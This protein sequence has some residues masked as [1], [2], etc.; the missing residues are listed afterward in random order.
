MTTSRTTRLTVPGGELRVEQ[1]GAGPAIVLLHG[2]YLTAASWDGQIDDLSAAH[3]VV[4]YDARSQGGSSTA[5][6]DFH[7]DDDLLAVLDAFGIERAALVGN[8]MGGV[9][10]FDFALAHPERV[11]ALVSASGGIS[12]MSFDNEPFVLEQQALQARA[13][14]C[15]DGEAFVEA[16][17][18]YGVDGPHRAPD[19]TPPHVRDRCRAM[20]MQ[21]I[22]A[23]ATATG[24]MLT[25]NA[26]RRLR[27]I[28]APTLFLVGDL[29]LRTLHD[30]ADQGVAT[31]PA[32][33]KVVLSGGHALN[34]ERPAEF[35]RAVLEFLDAVPIA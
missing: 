7:P 8:S 30:L 24:A 6:V 29:D 16:F 23:H 35:N 11:S 13:I 25:G 22:Q 27:E 21:T 1:Y 32:A 4:R 20:A 34:M 19:E 33:R 18:R 31:M 10:A 5:T 3:N 14:E 12:P 2:G 9:T 17:L 26:R 15:W 28:A